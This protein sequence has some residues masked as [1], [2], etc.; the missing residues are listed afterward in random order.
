MLLQRL[1]TAAI[2]IPVIVAVIWIGAA[3]LAGVVAAAVAVAMLEIGAARGA[4][5][6]L[7]TLLAAALT[8]SLPVAALEGADWLLRGVA[9]AVLLTTAAVVVTRTPGEGI[10]GWLWGIAGVMYFGFLAAHFVLLREV[11]DGRDWLFFA[12]L[13]VW[14]ADTGAYF[15]GYS[16]SRAWGG[17]K[18]APSISP[19]KTIEGA[20]GQIVAGLLAV[21]GL[22][23]AFDLGLKARDVIALGL[24]IP[25]VALLGDLAESALKRSLDVKDSSGLV[26]GHGGVADRLDSLLFALPVV[27]YY[28]DLV[29]RA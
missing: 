11:A 1:V 25:V 15:V 27:Y 21:V 14:I 6:R 20:I 28:L 13:A 24:I 29:V 7:P 3:L 12:V 4:M 17:H 26:P 22:N 16:A 5:L 18:L 19:G 8:A 10:D 2:G 9:L 23:E